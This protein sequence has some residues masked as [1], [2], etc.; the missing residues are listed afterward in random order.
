M[1]NTL[2][3]VANM[4][5]DFIRS[6]FDKL[7]LVYVIHVLI[8]YERWDMV[9]TVLGAIIMLTTGKVLQRNGNGAPKK[10]GE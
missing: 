2:K 7:L 1:L 3:N 5:E 4:L 10:E 6:N 8:V 9:N